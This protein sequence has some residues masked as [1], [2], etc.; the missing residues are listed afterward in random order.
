MQSIWIIKQ[1]GSTPDLPVGIRQ[2][3]F[4]QSLAQRGYEVSFF[5][6]SFHYLLHKTIKPISQTTYR[7]EKR[8]GIN[9]VWIKG[10]PYTLNNWRRAVNVIDFALRFYITSLSIANNASGI[11]PPDYIIAF[12]LPLS[13]P[14]CAYFLSRKF[15]ARFFLEVGDIWPQTL[16]DLGTA[17]RR[18][19]S[20]RCLLF[21]NT[22]L[23]SGFR[24]KG[25]GLEA[26]KSSL[27]IRTHHWILI[28]QK[29]F[30]TLCI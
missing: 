4:A 20:R 6:S 25:Y 23:R 1:Y 15:R 28:W 17:M 8:D 26:A 14:L 19:S 24:T 18:I 21:L 13:T 27:T 29:M 2:Y 10:F 11:R 5:L 30:S 16:V 22:C 3:T 12:N 9:L 7:V